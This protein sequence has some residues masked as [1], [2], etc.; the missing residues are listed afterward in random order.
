MRYDALGICASPFPGERAGIG[1]HSRCSGGRGRH[2]R[3]LIVVMTMALSWSVTVAGPRSGKR[4]RVHAS[5]T[6]TQVRDGVVLLG[7]RRGCANPRGRRVGVPAEVVGCPRVR[8]P[9]AEARF[10]LESLRGGGAGRGVS[11]RRGEGGRVD[12]RRLRRPSRPGSRVSLRPRMTLD[13]R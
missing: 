9:R 6:D 12:L 5:V 2:D 8:R 13:I 1:G 11:C 4:G 10:W 3:V 7:E